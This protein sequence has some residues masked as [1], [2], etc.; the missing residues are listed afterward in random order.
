MIE[1]RKMGYFDEE[2]PHED[3][4]IVSVI[5]DTEA[6]KVVKYKYN[7]DKHWRDAFEHDRFFNTILEARIALE[8]YNRE[9]CQKSVKMLFDECSTRRG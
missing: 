6:D 9:L 7:D 3:A 2:Y 4:E 8:D 1:E 5:Y